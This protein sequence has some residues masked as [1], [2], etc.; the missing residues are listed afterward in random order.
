VGSRGVDRV[1]ISGMAA[2]MFC[3]RLSCILYFYAHVHDDAVSHLGKRVLD[4]ATDS[5]SSGVDM[6][7]LKP[8]RR[9]S[10]SQR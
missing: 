7:V 1:W 6:F 5:A 9:T 4:A 8:R 3:L 10:C 2:L